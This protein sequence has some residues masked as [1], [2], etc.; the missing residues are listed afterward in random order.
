M[1]P[2]SQNRRTDPVGAIINDI[3]GAYVTACK[4][5]LSAMTIGWVV[6]VGLIP[7]KPLQRGFQRVDNL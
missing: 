2:P 7:G 1:C 5:G 4:T 3:S 6:L